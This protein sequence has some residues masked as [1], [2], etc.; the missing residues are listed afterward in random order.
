M[1]RIL[2]GGRRGGTEVKY[3]ELEP[4]R[5]YLQER[6][7]N[8]TA[9][10]YYS[11]VVKLFQGTNFNSLEEIPVSYLERELPARFRTR[12]EFS[13]AKNG[14][15]H[16]AQFRPG[17]QLPEEA[18][19]RENSLK[20]RNFSRKPGKIIYLNPVRRTI[21]QIQNVK[22][23]YAYRLALVSG[24]RVSELA[25]LEAPDLSF[26]DGSIV[27]RVKKDKGG[28]GGLIRCRADSWLYGK[29]QSYTQEN[30]EGKLF[31]GEA[32]MRKEADRLGFECHDLRR[33]YA[34]ETRRE[35]GKRMS[36]EEADRLV[37]ENL[38]HSRFST[39]KRYLY[40]RKLKLEY[41]HK[42]KD[43]KKTG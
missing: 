13:A 3:D 19:Y 43:R 29:L 26:E 28:K 8:N 39:T 9:R 21:N 23:K 41:G 25:D 14:L 15:K 12:N 30:S 4:F 35:L 33:I 32:Y 27:V 42:E 2:C 18:F 5:E 36:P 11:A 10:T 6:L 17:L 16:L 34:I 22:L 40:N 38:R 24:L 37:Q 7:C 20:K 1:K 31:Y